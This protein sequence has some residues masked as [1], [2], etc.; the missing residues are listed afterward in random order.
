MKKN[1]L[2]TLLLVACHAL[3]A[4]AQPAKWVEKAKRAVFSVI[5]Y[6]DNNQ[7]LNSG[8]GFFISDD[9]VAL[10]DYTLFKGAK[11]AVIVNADGKQMPVSLIL[12]ANTEY[13]VVKFRVDIGSKKVAALT[14]SKAT[15]AVDEEVYLLPYSTKKDR[16]YTTGKVDALFAI[17]DQSSYYTLAMGLNDKQA[18]CPLMTAAGEVFAL[19]QKA[20]SQKEAATVCYGVGVTYAASL[21]VNALSGNDATYRSIGIKTGLPESEDAALVNLFVASSQSSPEEY[22]ALLDDFVAKF[23]E[24][25]DGYLRRA[26]IFVYRDQ[27]DLAGAERDL[28]KA[29][30][31]AENKDDIHYNQAKLIYTYRLTGP[32]QK[33]ESWSLQR[34]LN[35]V[36]AAIAI[37]P[38]PVYQQLQGDI[39]FAMHNYEAAFEAYMLV[40]ESSLVSPQTYFNAAKTK[41]VM[42]GDV[43]D[44]I[45]L[46]DSCV[47][48]ISKPVVAADAAYFLERAT[49]YMAAEM[50][51]PAMA[52]YD[53]YHTAVRGN[54]NDYFYYLRAQAAF[55]AR[56]FQRALD[57]INSAIAINP[58]E[59]TYHTELGVINLRV[60]RYVE[61]EAAFKKSTELD[62]N[63]AEGYRLLGLAQQQQKKE[64]EACANFAKAKELG[65]EAADALIEKFCK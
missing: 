53:T 12:G 15:P 63:Y 39:C 21:S 38:Q 2:I 52:D 28:K 23:P 40:N 8:N 54:V 9:G 35:E 4:G 13:D 64:K 65:D 5:T 51:R 31:L 27:P 60:G 42:G 45:A 55:S 56:Q 59:I 25:V 44:I 46:M 58:E 1:L 50:Y 26:T 41:E 3:T 37:N 33:D 43:K 61:A 62:A 34:A 29:M 32:E 19:A 7:I 48:R 16:T 47:A 20:T 57:D 6:D 10:S 17:N 49:Y 24:N 36:K 11:R 14:L 30:E 22:A 18:S